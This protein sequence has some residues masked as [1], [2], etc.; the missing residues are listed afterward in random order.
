MRCPKCN[1]KAFDKNYPKKRVFIHKYGYFVRKSDS[2]VIQRFRCKACSI[3]FSYAIKDPAYN[4]N[5]RRVNYPLLGLLASSV[6][7]RRAA[8]LLHISR[9]TVAKKLV[10]LAD[11]ARQKQKEFLAT[12]KED[13][14]QVDEL[15]TIE[16]TKCKPLSVAVAVSDTSRRILGMQV[17]SMPAT[18][19]LAAISRR[20]YGFR[21]DHRIKGLNRLFEEIKA[22][23][24]EHADFLSDEHPY[25]GKLIRRHY[26]KATHRQVKGAKSAVSGQGELKK[27]VKDPLFYINHTLAMLRANINRLI[28]KTWCTT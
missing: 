13:S 23:I 25:Y 8:K 11:L 3:T 2:K 14:I 6:S 20:K 24:S 22:A 21:P 18:G 26:P 1:R 7:M 12:I 9:T 27:K 28:R 19:H 10:F 15:Q 17:S 4:Q 5:K 16:H